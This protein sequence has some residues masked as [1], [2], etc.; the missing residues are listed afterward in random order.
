MRIRDSIHSDQLPK[1]YYADSSKYAE[2]FP[3]I[4]GNIKAEV[5]VIGGGFTGVASAL[6]LAERGIS[7]A[8][9][10]QNQVGWGAS[11]RNGGQIIGGLGPELSDF[12][13]YETTYGK[14][15]AESMWQAG[16]ECVDIVK[17]TIERYDIDCGLEWGY[18]DAA[19]NDRDMKDLEHAERSLKSL[20]YPHG[21]RLVS[22][23]DVKS[24]VGSERYIG[25]LINEG[26]GHC[27]P[28]NLVR[29]Q[30]KAAVQ[31]GAKIFEDARVSKLVYG[32]EKITVDMDWGRVTAD[33]VIIATN[34]YIGPLVPKLETLMLPAGSYIISTEPLNE[35]QVQSIL[36]G[37]HAVCDQRWALDYFRL[38]EDKRLLFGGV[39][40]YSGLHPKNVAAKMRPKMLKVFPQLENV[41]IEYQWGGY[42]AVSRNRV[43]Q[44]GRL[45]ERTY[46]AQA[47]SGHG[48]AASHMAARFIVEAMEG[49]DERLSMM[50]AVA[51]KPFPG[52]SFFRVPLLA[53]GMALERMK[54]A[55]RR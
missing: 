1:S 51:H 24:I 4:E 29:G 54:E 20:N 46:Y 39:A 43:P 11:G 12:D 14:D 36:P 17:Q 40:A 7:V 55:F 16:L 18:F 37:N 19:M 45:D 10:E 53:T 42:L 34:A 35:D 41:R 47:Y 50:E 21:Q 28:L 13:A 30:A 2:P 48:V 27:H 26:W 33:K 5:C 15:A 9:V 25:G 32:T 8:L 3:R 52:G 31:L 23:A 49:N 22:G 6:A 44:I 38:S